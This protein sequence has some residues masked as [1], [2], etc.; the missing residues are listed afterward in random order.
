M[1]GSLLARNILLPIVMN[2]QYVGALGE[3]AYRSI[4]I[5]GS[6]I[7]IGATLISGIIYAWGALFLC[8]I[9]LGSI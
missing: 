1:L 7:I 6:P 5:S 2:Q 3:G 4:I 9:S 8:F